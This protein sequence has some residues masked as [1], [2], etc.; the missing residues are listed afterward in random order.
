MSVQN[1]SC[2]PETEAFSYNCSLQYVYTTGR[3]HEIHIKHVTVAIWFS[4]V[5]EALLSILLYPD[6]V[7][8]TEHTFRST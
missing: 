6:I 2:C 7:S 1:S 5:L 3:C 4:G 8:I